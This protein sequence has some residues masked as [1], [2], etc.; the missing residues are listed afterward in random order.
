MD[1]VMAAWSGS[2][3]GQ[4]VHGVAHDQRRLGRVDDDDGLALLRAAHLLDRAGGG[5]GELVDVLA[6]A[7][8]GALG[9]DTVATISP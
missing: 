2:P 7:G 9:L 8:A 1:S 5:A 3:L 6:G 4:A